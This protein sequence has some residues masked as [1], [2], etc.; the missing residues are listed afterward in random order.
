MK[1]KKETRRN[2]L[3][4]W[5]EYDEGGG[6]KNKEMLKKERVQYYIDHFDKNLKFKYQNCC[7]I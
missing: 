6:L 4:K 2:E 3:Y 5:E 7:F 1:R